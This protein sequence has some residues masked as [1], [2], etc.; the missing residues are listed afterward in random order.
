MLK[1]RSLFALDR[2]HDST[3][4]TTTTSTTTQQQQQQHQRATKDKGQ[5]TGDMEQ[6]PPAVNSDRQQHAPSAFRFPFSIF[7]P[8]SVNFGRCLIVFKR[9][10]KWR[11]QSP[12]GG[13]QKM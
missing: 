2:R 3:T 12:I 6:E 11:L 7:R 1:S 13:W 5:G 8:G 4:S 9:L 10:S